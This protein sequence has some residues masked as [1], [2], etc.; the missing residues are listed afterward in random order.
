MSKVE[1]PDKVHKE[2]KKFAVDHDMTIKDAYAS[3]IGFALEQKHDKLALKK[4]L[5]D[6][7][8]QDDIIVGS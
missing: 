6:K 3:L 7:P 4:I 2:V 5:K 1:I 8:G